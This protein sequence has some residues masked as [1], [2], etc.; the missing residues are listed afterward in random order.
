MQ[1]LYNDLNQ[2]IKELNLRDLS[3]DYV[4]LYEC[5]K[6]LG[7]DM[8]SDLFQE[9][10]DIIRIKLKLNPGDIDAV[11]TAVKAWVDG[12]LTSKSIDTYHKASVKDGVI[13]DL[14]AK[15]TVGDIL[16]TN[17]QRQILSEV[18]TQMMDQVLL[19]KNISKGT[20]FENVMTNQIFVRLKPSFELRDNRVVV[21]MAKPM[22]LLKHFLPIESKIVTIEG[23]KTRVA[24]VK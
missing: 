5:F 24:V 15:Y 11:K 18:V 20:A 10:D 22:T 17:D 6:S 8:C 4:N 7:I 16:S 2:A 21:D 14:R 1:I 12:S 13:S 3:V 19:V 23:K 9:M